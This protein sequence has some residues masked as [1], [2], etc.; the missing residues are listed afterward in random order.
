MHEPQASDRPDEAPDPAKKVR[1][2][3][4][5][6]GVYMMKDAAGVVIYVGKAKN[7]R[8]R[9]SSYFHKA[10][11]LELRTAHWIDE[12]RD[13]DYLPCDS[14]VDALLVESRLIKDIQPQ[15]QQGA[16]GRQDL[17]VPADHDARGLSARRV[18]SRAVRAGGEAV[19][20]VRQRRLA[21]R[22]DPGPAADLQVPHVRAG[23]RRRR[24]SLEMVSPVPAGEHPSVHGPLQAAHQQGR[25]SPRHSPPA[26]V[27]GGKQDLAVGTDAP[28]DDRGRGAVG[29]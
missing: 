4:T 23:H 15:A 11:E 6:P 9:A 18:D 20:P 17:S 25:L 12:I 26:D 3:P 21:P 7:L 13:I 1:E 19:R 16:Q 27:S 8:S 24:P 22:R 29:V 14:E 10:A 28:G 2:F 5:T